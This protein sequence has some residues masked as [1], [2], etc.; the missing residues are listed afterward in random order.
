MDRR[1]HG[2]APEFNLPDR[3]AEP[4]TN[5]MKAAYDWG[6]A[7]PGTFHQVAVYRRSQRY[8]KNQVYGYQSQHV[9]VSDESLRQSVLNKLQQLHFPVGFALTLERALQA[10]I[11]EQEFQALLAKR[12]RRKIFRLKNSVL[13]REVHSNLREERCKFLRV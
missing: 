13:R 1:R 11:M 12:T 7:R 9:A 5:I 10:G 2:A 8:L 6:M 3:L 4:Q